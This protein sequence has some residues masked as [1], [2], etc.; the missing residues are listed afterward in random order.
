MSE[1]KNNGAQQETQQPRPRP[2][3]S[4]ASMQSRHRYHRT[5]SRLND[6]NH[7]SSTAPSSR[8][9]ESVLLANYN[10]VE[11]MH[12]QAHQIQ[13]PQRP[14]TAASRM[15][16]GSGGIGS[17]LSSSSMNIHPQ[18]LPPM[19]R[20][21]RSAS[22]APGKVNGGTNDV[23]L[24]TQN[25]SNNPPKN[26]DTVQLL[27]P[28]GHRLY[29]THYLMH[30]IPNA[31]QFRCQDLG[32]GSSKQ[33]RKR[34]SLADN[35][36]DIS[37]SP[38]AQQF[39]YFIPRKFENFQFILDY[40]MRGTSN[41]MALSVLHAQLRQ[42]HVTQLQ[43]L[44]LD[45]KFLHLTK[46]FIMLTVYLRRL[47]D[48]NQKR[49]YHC[50]LDISPSGLTVTRDNQ[51]N[52]VLENDARWLAA[53]VPFAYEKGTHH[54][55]VLC[56]GTDLM[57]G[58]TNE[59]LSLTPLDDERQRDRVC[60]CFY[61]AH[62]GT[63]SNGDSEPCE[64]G[65]PCQYGDRLGIYLD[66]D[67]KKVQFYRND[68]PLGWI[69]LPSEIPSFCFTFLLRDGSLEI[70]PFAKKPTLEDEE[71]LSKSYLLHTE[72]KNPSVDGVES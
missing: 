38:S 5:N 24:F 19:R 53:T 64:Y 42:M 28:C 44:C 27:F 59:P 7:S 17:T 23:S 65:E 21:Q 68:A 45:A 49:H 36:S 54:L 48:P 1:T 2:M 20:P 12:Q 14:G 50:A 46:L 41:E 70:L 62:D 3:S 40:L 8:I 67:E 34:I 63:F 9:D 35:E 61:N 30:K 55:E 52:R 6:P 22:A 43:E 4:H 16:G 56:I 57:V 60:C 58:V 72:S 15:K 26:N 47:V 39:S 32:S 66:M 69:S 13:K 37:S 25:S 71:P 51:K 31:H 33:S 11:N 18:P 10:D 29:A